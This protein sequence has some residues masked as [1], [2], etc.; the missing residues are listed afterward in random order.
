VSTRVKYQIPAAA[1]VIGGALGLG[2]LGRVL[3]WVCTSSA[4]VGTNIAFGVLGSVVGAPFVSLFGVVLSALVEVQVRQLRALVSAHPVSA[5]RAWWALAAFAGLLVASAIVAV[6]AHGTGLGAAGWLV[7]RLLVAVLIGGGTAILAFW[8]TL[9]GPA[10]RRRVPGLVVA[11]IVAVGAFLLSAGEDEVGVGISVLIVIGV[12]LAGYAKGTANRFRRDRTSFAGGVLGV[13]HLAGLSLLWLGIASDSESTVPVARFAVQAVIAAVLG[14]IVAP[15]IWRRSRASRPVVRWL[16]TAATVLVAG[17]LVFLVLDDQLLGGALVAPLFPVVVWL[18]I[19][20]WR[21]MGTARRIGVKAAA[22]VV[23]ALILGAV[24]VSL[25]AWLANL[26]ALSTVEAQALKEIAAA[27]HDAVELSPWIWFGIYLVLA[28]VQLFAALGPR[29]YQFLSRRLASLRVVPTVTVVH[30]AATM[31]GIALM[32]VALLGLAVPPTTGPILRSQVQAAY[33]VAAQQELKDD[34]QIAVYQAITTGLTRSRPQLVYLA[35]LVIDVHDAAG[36]KAQTESD[37]AHRLG[38]L[39][40]QLIAIN[41]APVEPP[42]APRLDG[43]LR[44]QLDAEQH[45]DTLKQARDKQAESAAELSANMITSLLDLISLGHAEVLSIVHEYVNGLAESPLG[46]IFLDWTKRALNKLQPDK[47][48]AAADVVEPDPT[49]LA[50]ATELAPS[51]GPPAA[52]IKAA[53]SAEN[54]AVTLEQQQAQCP[55]CG[56]S[57]DEPGHDEPAHE[58]P[59]IE[60][61]GGG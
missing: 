46:E 20:L 23:F 28:A 24:L 58:P 57:N 9:F 14:T 26:L 6:A 16:G 27:T 53:V 13:L 1:W 8:P 22:D 35:D 61:H 39:Q 40:G 36:G 21:H 45:E 47:P 60:V 48:P 4:G 2:V 25:L 41:Q 54:Q 37:L 32:V 12:M 49:G 33:T 50:F 19:R 55:D 51:P 30:R 17:Y 42:T 10:I 59:P 56:L 38:L 18:G 44:Q 29:K 15:M 52:E 3:A 7:T 11:G 31:A 5:R 43:G 34:E